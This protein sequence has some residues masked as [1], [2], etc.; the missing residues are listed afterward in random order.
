MAKPGPRSGPSV[1]SDAA[2]PSLTEHA[3]QRPQHRNTGICMKGLPMVQTKE[4]TKCEITQARGRTLKVGPAWASPGARAASFEEYRVPTRCLPPLW[5]D[6]HPLASLP[7]ADCKPG[8][9]FPASAPKQA[10]APRSLK[11]WATPGAPTREQMASTQRAI[12]DNRV[13]G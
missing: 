1:H 2:P 7:Q 13:P 8:F 10:E 4:E 5:K 3:R 11:V 6:P 12:W 9:R